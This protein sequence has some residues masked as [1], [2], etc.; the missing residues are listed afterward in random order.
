MVASAAVVYL[1]VFAL[2][3]FVASLMARGVGLRLGG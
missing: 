1:V 3:A 2:I